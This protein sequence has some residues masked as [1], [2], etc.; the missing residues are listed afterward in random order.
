[1]DCAAWNLTLGPLVN[2]EKEQSCDPAQDIAQES[3][4][5][6]GQTG[7]AVGRHY[8]FS[9][10]SLQLYIFRLGLLQDGKLLVSVLPEGQKTLKSSFRL[11]TVP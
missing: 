1:M 8:D 5:T 11:C 3:C 7:L 4:Y 9:L 6:F 2:E 10:T